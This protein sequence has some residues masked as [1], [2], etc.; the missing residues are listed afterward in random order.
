MQLTPELKGLM[1]DC[2]SGDIMVSMKAQR[3]FA[4]AIEKHLNDQL[5]PEQKAG[6]ATKAKAE[7]IREGNMWGDI[8]AGLVTKQDYPA[9]TTVEIP[10][11]LLA[12]GMEKEHVAYVMPRQG[13]IPHRE[14]Q[15]DYVQIPTFKVANAIDCEIDYIEAA[16]WPVT[17]AMISLFGAGFVKKINDDVW[18]TLLAAAVDRNIIVYDADASQGQM[19]KRVIKLLQS[20]MKRN[21][22]GNST[23]MNRFKLT[24]IFLSVEA[25]GD[26]WQWNVD[27]IDEATRRDI[28]R[29]ADG[30]VLN[31]MGVNLH[32]L[33]EL[34]VGQEYQNFFANEL[35]GSLPA[36]DEEIFIGFDLTKTSTNIMPVRKRITVHED[37]SLLRSGKFGVFGD[38]AY[39][40][41]ALDNRPILLGSLQRY[42]SGRHLTNHK[43]SPDFSG[44]FS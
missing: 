33:F 19:T 5:F 35:S 13:Y 24:D 12:P 6:A 28:Y 27:Q 15:G 21:G 8:T 39:G 29:T 18:H 22:G 30:A 41:A 9:G 36:G 17:Q 31:V 37:P 43:L 42:Y 40:V 26:V 4:K 32:E 11:H 14:V 16:N 34:G 20:T 2:A 1:K 3:A 44:D 10:L 38:A 7:V 25:L 23:S